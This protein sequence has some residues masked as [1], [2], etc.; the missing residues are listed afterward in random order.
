MGSKGG[1]QSSIIQSR[2]IHSNSFIHVHAGSSTV[3]PCPW[4]ATSTGGNRP[5]LLTT[6]VNARAERDSLVL[7]LE[8]SHTKSN[9]TQIY[10]F[11]IIN[12]L[13]QSSSGS[14]TCVIVSHHI[15]S[16]QLACRSHGARI[17]KVN[18]KICIKR[19]CEFKRNCST[20]WLHRATCTLRR[21]YNWDTT[22][23]VK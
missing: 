10:L 2:F 14:I 12:H 7:S 8:K 4:T 21:D 16:H 5:S 11:I 23:S 13:Y 9:C 15:A 17:Q 20:R 19:R 18:W 3:R 22:V 6:T 1:D